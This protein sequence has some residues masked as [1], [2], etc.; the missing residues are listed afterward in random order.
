MEEFWNDRYREDIYAYGV[1]PNK[2]FAFQL[3]KLE[4]KKLL[5][6]A[7]G[8]GRNAVYAAQ[9]QWE[10]NAFDISIE[11]RK[12]AVKLAKEKQV[13]INYQVGSL[14]D[15]DYADSYFD[16]IGLIYAHLPSST[17]L[18]FHKALVKKLK[19]GGYLILE[20]F[21]KKN[22]AL[23]E[24]NPKIGG[25]KDLSMLFDTETIKS[26]F[27]E[28]ETVYLKEELIVLREGKYHNG[29]ASV[30]RYVGVKS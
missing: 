25:P 8:E 12:K 9:K 27:S 14:L 7:E 15:L 4:P 16:A 30:I 3:D 29:Q 13:S 10:V 2:F 24:A 19:H 23:S 11:G 6:P 18:E 1:E 20:G 26:D 17:R 28:L 21:S 5:L 22:L